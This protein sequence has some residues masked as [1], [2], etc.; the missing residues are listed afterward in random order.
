MSSI[1]A[2]DESKDD[3]TSFSKWR[4][5]LWPIHGSELKKFV[6]LLFMKC[7]VSFNYTI[8]H[9]TKDTIIVT[10]KG[11]GAE[12]IPILKGWV[13][14]VFAFLWMLLY[15]KL[16]NVLSKKKL[17]YTT[18]APFLV[19]FA[20]YGFFLYPNRDW[21]SPHQ[22]AD[23]LVSLV[24]EER[25]HW[26]VVFRYW[27]DSLFF[28]MAEFWGGIV[29][30]V[31]YWGFLNQISTINEASRFY[32]LLSAGGHIG[33]IAAGPLI[34]HYASSFSQDQY[35]MT[36]QTLMTVVTVVC[37]LIMGIY[38]W[39]N[40]YVVD[41]KS[42]VEKTS[43]PKKTK[44]KL[45]LKDSLIHIIKNPALGCIA[46]MVIG[47]GLSVNMVEVAWKGIL[48]IQY[49][50]SNDYQAFMGVVS[51]ATGVVSLILALLVSGNVIRKFGWHVGAQ[52][53]P[54]VLGIASIAFY[55]L[56]FMS[57]YTTGA[58]FIAGTATLTLIVLCGA[59]HN[60]A[61]KSMKYCLFDPTK[62]M[63]YIPL[64][65]ETKVKGKAAVDVV[66]ARFGKS[67]S[68]WLQLALMEIVGVGSVLSIIPYLAPIVLVAI[69]GWTAAVYSLNKKSQGNVA[70]NQLANAL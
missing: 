10:S 57:G 55:A 41:N 20:L 64:D 36:V 65:D 67:G 60:V 47:Y 24:G 16:S 63:A 49:P 44:Y 7:C 2:L 19:F 48:K 38:W 21:L 69:A 22:T 29:I 56:F 5:R 68:S 61:C 17:F 23:W 53:T 37:V 51:S 70:E 30:L 26:I 8:L 28:L 52:S 40:R 35:S 15:S 45:T 43:A 3:L 6:P 11:S 59:A 50:E 46:L 18:L 9:A 58:P 12:A 25:S 14:L 13:V 31:L 34:W 54:V 32:T 27:M 66:G 4:R 39:M 42:N 1:S 62:E 33:V